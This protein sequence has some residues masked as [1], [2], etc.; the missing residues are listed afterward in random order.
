MKNLVWA[1]LL[2][3]AVPSVSLAS[4]FVV[5]GQIE[6]VGEDSVTVDYW[7]FDLATPGN[8]TIDT[9]SMNFYD[10]YMDP[11][12][13]LFVDDGVLQ[14]ED[15]IAA[16]DDSDS[17][18]GDGSVHRYDSYLGRYLDA[19]SYLLA[20]SM[21]SFETT[22]AVAGVN[23]LIQFRCD[24]AVTGPC[25]HADYQ[26]TFTGVTSVDGAT[27][28]TTSPVPVPPA[29]AL[30]GGAVLMLGGLRRRG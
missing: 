1:A 24:S 23:D 18:Y 4:T 20:I 28:T 26:I 3:A 10:Y 25:D 16:N 30:L 21:F 9:L 22:D 13:R 11:H 7:A 12:I 29:A 17:T 15:E 6:M 8:V 5:N 14:A 27:A 2:A 19:G